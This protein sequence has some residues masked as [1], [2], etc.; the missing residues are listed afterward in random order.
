M[1][2]LL[3][4]L[5]LFWQYGE[6]KFD[7]IYQCGEKYVESLKGRMQ[8]DVY[9]SVGASM[10]TILDYGFLAP[11]IR[12]TVGQEPIMFHTSCLSENSLGNS[13][14][15]YF[16]ARLCA[17]FSGAHYMDLS[18]V[19]QSNTFFTALGNIHL[20][21]NPL[22]LNVVADKI[23]SLC[24][25]KSICHEWRNGLVHSN[26]PR[27]KDMFRPAISAYWMSPQTDKRINKDRIFLSNFAEELPV[28]PDVAIHYRCGDN[29]VTHYGFLKFSSLLRLI[30]STAKSIF[31][32]AESPSR[33]S[34]ENQVERCNDI[35]H[36][37]Y[38]YL[39]AN[40]PHTKVAIIRGDNVFNDLARLTFAGTTICSVSTFCLWPAI[41]SNTSAYFP[42]TKLIAKEDTSFRYGPNF[43]WIH[44]PI[45]LG[46][47]AA[48]LPN[49]RLV[50]ELSH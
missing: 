11:P 26:M 48:H 42:V 12:R 14:S 4:L 32:L 38:Q 30:P 49:S 23:S 29:I 13:L 8:C 37:M 10:N 31:I 45:I 20:H 7:E 28:I 3:F 1:N 25:C 46:S 22:P 2:V 40:L 6:S 36:G 27:V 44:E 24:R 34:R 5:L 33:R 19:N 21:A 41:S 15:E 9:H 47:R 50:S 35:F 16:E 43:H 39:L 18:N 17:N